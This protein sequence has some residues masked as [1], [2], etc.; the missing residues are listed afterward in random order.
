MTMRKYIIISV[1]TVCS[2]SAYAQFNQSISVEGKYVPEIFRL[3]RINSFPKQVKFSLDTR[4]LGYDAK[5]VPAGFAPNLFPMPATG[6]NDSREF[7]DARG[8]LELGAGSWLN[9]TLSAGY[10]FIDDKATTFGIRLQHNSTSLWK[11]NVSELMQ[12]TKQ[13]RY[14]ENIGIYGSHDFE[15]KGKLSGAIDYHIGNFNYYGFDPQW[16]AFQIGNAPKVPTQTLN[17][18]AARF[19]WQSPVAADKLSWNAGVGVRYFGYRANYSPFNGYLGIIDPDTWTLASTQGCRETDLNLNGG[20][21]LPLSGGSSF[22]VDLNAD[23]LIYPKSELVAGYVGVWNPENYSVVTLTPYYRFSRERLL[24]RIGADI[25]LAFNAGEEDG[26]DNHK[27]GFLHIAPDVKVDYLAGPVSFYLHALGGTR[28]NTLAS[29]YERDYYQSPDLG[30]SCPVYSPLDGSLG[31]TFGPFSGFSAGIDFAFRIT[32]GEY[33]GGWYQS[34]M[35]Y[36]STTIPGLP[37]TAYIDRVDREL[38]YNYSNSDYYNLHGFSLGARAS[39]DAGKI[40]KVEAKGNY[41]PQNGNNGY[42][43]GYDRPRWTALI[44]AETNPWKGLKFKLAYEYRGVRNI[45]AMAHYTGALV[46]DSQLLAG[47]RLPD[48]TYLNFGASYSFTKNFSLWAQAD[49]LLNRHDEILPSLPSQ[50]LRVTGGFSLIF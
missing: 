11:P 2:A 5:S 6:W 3:D 40:F 29:N 4:P 33:I 14:D 25:D 31:A 35:N 39:Y 10:R 12:D 43:N 8:Y 44:S 49:N 15:G 24:V 45:Y 7:S 20:F 21:N 18:I 37:E 26:G 19:S 13:A 32:R 17:D 47:Y 41:Q 23:I 42:F 28:L 1:L 16:G 27:Y 22:G 38:H 50:G 36:G 34:Y 48:I 46:S 30:S 9:S